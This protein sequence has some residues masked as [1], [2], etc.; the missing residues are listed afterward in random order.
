[1]GREI[2]DP[3]E[4]KYSLSNAP[5]DT[6]APRLAFMPGQRYWIERSFQDGKSQAGLD[7]Y[8][9][10][11]WKAWHHHMALVMMAML[12]MLNERVRHK[13]SYPLLSCSDI[14]ELLS[15]FLPRRDVTREEVIRQLEYRH[16]KR[17]AAIQSHSR[18]NNLRT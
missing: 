18:N 8:Q 4:I 3:T 1:M 12:F 10:R 11:G 6:P 7:H 14:E 2:D 5:A 13:D 9:A 17:L 15:R 16:R